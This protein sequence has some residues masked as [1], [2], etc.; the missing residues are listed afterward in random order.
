MSTPATETATA[1]K[2]YNKIGV[3]SY[4]ISAARKAIDLAQYTKR[5]VCCLVGEAGIGKTHVVR[6]AAEDRKPKEP[7]MWNG[8]EWKDSV[9]LV[10]LPLAQM[11]SEDTGMP[12]LPEFERDRLVREATFWGD[13]AKGAKSPV[14]MSAEANHKAIVAKLQQEDPFK[15]SS[16]FDF[17]LPKT[18]ADLP[19]EGILFLD[20][21]NRADKAVVKAFFTLVEDRHIHNKRIPEG[22]QIVAAMNPSEGAYVVNEA[23]K[24]HAIRRRLT[25]VAVN[26]NLSAFLEHATHRGKFHKHVVEFVRSMPPY[27]HDTKRRDV[28]KV[29][30]CPA[31]WESVSEVLQAAEEMKVS[32][33]DDTVTL[34][35]EGHIGDEAGRKFASFIQDSDMVINPSDVIKKYTEKSSV[36]SRVR[37]L[38]DANRNDVLD[39]L[40]S[41]LAATL[42]SERPDA[43]S[44]AAQLALF[45]G[46]LPEEVAISFVAN[47]MASESSESNDAEKYFGK[48]SVALHTQKPYAMLLGKIMD[49]M[50][51]GREASRDQTITEHSI[52]TP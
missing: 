41:G 21:W 9:P 39:E 51:K 47:K 32:L 12:K 44:I 15:V 8:L 22:I 49:A 40:C 37:K 28:G 36:R 52:I 35:I 18:I 33:S 7:F 5:S 3:N 30:P 2:F 25:F 27:L 34:L 31:K 38:V 29:Y 24:D 43:D 19:P 6:Q 45:M 10:L 42:F 11:Q 17:V 4:G 50:K 23:E 13:L 16:G 1:D 26:T 48:L 20:E 14:Q 46:D